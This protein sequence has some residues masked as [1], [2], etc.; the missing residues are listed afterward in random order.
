MKVLG[1]PGKMSDLKQGAAGT[2]G[3]AGQDM[4]DGLGHYAGDFDVAAV[5]KGLEA[6]TDAQL[7]DVRTRAEWTFVGVADLRPIGKSAAFVEWQ[8]FPSMSVN[9][10]FVRQLEAEL[11]RRGVGKDA[12]IYFLCRSGARSQSAAAAA[13]AAGFT[14]AYNVA[15]G[16]EGP[17]GPDG[18]R[19]AVDG[20]K[21][22]GLPWVQS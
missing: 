22:A 13:T 10:D 6:E 7:V 14:A 15:G 11:G 5:W 8:S 20:W 4:A 21:A 3:P 17:V 19:G 16:F 1:P 2:C 12:P 9:P 18:R